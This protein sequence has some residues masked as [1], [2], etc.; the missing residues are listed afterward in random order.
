MGK[1]RGCSLVQTHNLAQLVHSLKICSDHA[2]T[3]LTPVIYGYIIP[4]PRAGQFRNLRCD[5]NLIPVLRHLPLIIF[6]IRGVSVQSLLAGQI[7][8]LT[9][10]GQLILILNLNTD[11]GW[12][13]IFSQ[14]L[15]QFI[16][17]RL[18]ILLCMPAHIF[19][20][21]LDIRNIDITCCSKGFHKVRTFHC[22]CRIHNHQHQQRTYAEGQNYG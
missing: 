5:C 4:Y 10:E 12:H 16:Q 18:H 15:C 14:N 1:I 17:P 21:L 3:R 9:F 22:L 11:L 20:D 8:D 2:L 6:V 13:S 7:I 19:H